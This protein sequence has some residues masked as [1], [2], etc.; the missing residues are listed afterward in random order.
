MLQVL[1]K[2]GWIDWLI[3]NATPGH[4]A[5]YIRDRHKELARRKPMFQFRLAEREAEN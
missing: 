5:E 2:S 1:L 3:E 4:D